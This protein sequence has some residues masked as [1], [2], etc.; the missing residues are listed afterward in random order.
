MWLINLNLM[1]IDKSSLSRLNNPVVDN[2]ARRKVLY[3]N[4]AK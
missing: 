1:A 4:R 2:T 3:E